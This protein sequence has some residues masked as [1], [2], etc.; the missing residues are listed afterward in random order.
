VLETARGMSM[1]MMF[2]KN[3][4]MRERERSLGLN[5]NNINPLPQSIFMAVKRKIPNN[6]PE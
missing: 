4:E 3:L 2:C 1:K 5:K 6:K